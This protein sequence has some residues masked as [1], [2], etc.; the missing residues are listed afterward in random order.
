MGSEK[1]GRV[2]RVASC[3][4]VSCRLC[5]LAFSVPSQFYDLTDGATIPAWSGRGNI[6]YSVLSFSPTQS[7]ILTH[8]DDFVELV[9][10]N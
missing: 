7:N 2:T 4:V 3:R 8:A 10:L 1:T 5:E 9:Y 6:L